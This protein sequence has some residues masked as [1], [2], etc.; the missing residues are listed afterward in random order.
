[1]ATSS[2][3][4]CE[5]VSAR[6]GDVH[7]TIVRR[8]DLAHLVALKRLAGRQQDVTDYGTLWTI[9]HKRAATGS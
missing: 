8:A 1:L 2:A 3:A 7:G 4:D 5:E 9:A 6:Y